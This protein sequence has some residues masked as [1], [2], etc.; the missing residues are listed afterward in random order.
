MR[1]AP[2]KSAQLMA[3]YRANA[4]LLVIR[5]TKNWVQVEDQDTGDV[6]FMDKAF[7]VK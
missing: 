1:W 6:G 7:V 2:S 4:Q 5:E 3:T